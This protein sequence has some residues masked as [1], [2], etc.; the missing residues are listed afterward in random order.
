MFARGQVRRGQPHFRQKGAVGSAANDRQFR[1][2]P[3]CPRG[4]NRLGNR[5][6]FLLQSVAQVAVLLPNGDLDRGPRI[7]AA[8]RA[9]SKS[10][11]MMRTEDSAT[12][13]SM[14]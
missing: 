12:P 14:W 4:F 10:R 13:P 8:S 9:V 6:R 11:R 3:G 7:L 5:P 1:F 2:K